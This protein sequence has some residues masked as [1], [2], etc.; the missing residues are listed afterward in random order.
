[1]PATARPVPEQTRTMALAKDRTSV[2]KISP[3]SRHST[4]CIPRG[5]ERQMPARPTR[6]SWSSA[7]RIMAVVATPALFA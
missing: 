3:Q 2:G 5:N 1:M 4:L 7:V 6:G